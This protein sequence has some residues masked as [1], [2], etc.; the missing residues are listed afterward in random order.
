G[1]L[2]LAAGEWQ[3]FVALTNDPS[4]QPTGDPAVLN[5]LGVCF[6][7]LSGD[8]PTL[9]LNAIDAFD[10]ASKIDPKA[11]EPV[12]NLVVTYRKLRL[13]RLADESLRRYSAID[14]ASPWHAEL[15][16][17]RRV[18]QASVLE[19]LEHAVATNNLAEAE[20]LFDANPELYRRAAMQH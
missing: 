10:L 2:Y 9:L 5:N 8:D 13:A 18:D 17:P 19:Q 12:F 16:N 20:L 1:L 15:V 3:K 6:L 11:A 4:S 14:S 7:A